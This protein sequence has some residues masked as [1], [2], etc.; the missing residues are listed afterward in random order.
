MDLGLAKEF[1]LSVK[2][3]A[4]KFRVYVVLVFSFVL[5]TI[6]ALAVFWP[7]YYVSS[8]TIVR[9]VTDVIGPLL[10]GAAPVAD[11]NKSEKVRD[12]IYSRKVMSRVVEKIDGDRTSMPPEVFEAKIEEI[13]SQLT[14]SVYAGNRDFTRIS[15]K[16]TS[17]DSA[18]DTLKA[19]VD[20]F[21]VDRIQNKK[22]KSYEAFE[23]ISKQAENY[24]RRLEV[25]EAN[26]KEFKAKSV[27]AT[28]GAVRSKISSL[29]SQLEDLKIEMDESRQIVESTRGQ[30]RVEGQ[31]VTLRK[32]LDVLESRRSGL[33]EQ[34][35]QLL[36]IYQDSYPD[37]ISIKEQIASVDSEINELVGELK[38]ESMQTELPLIEE[39]RKQNSTARVT[40]K[41]QKRR[42]EALQGLLEKELELADEVA[43]N[44]TALIELTRDYD[45]TKDLYEEMLA[46]K[47]SASLTLALN[48]EGQGESY[49]LTD[50]PSYPLKPS[51]LSALHVYLSA[52][53]IAAAIP[54]G[55][56]L[57]FVVLDPRIRMRSKVVS[58]LPE[59]VAFL[60]EV[61]HKTS[62]LSSKL[63]RKDI[64]IL[65]VF[66]VFVMSAYVYLL[67]FSDWIL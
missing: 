3:E 43:S 57:V 61:P 6:V 41:V 46:R 28:E 32:R 64:Y 21:L 25:A 9:D 60:G 56:I 48:D 39:L 13:K 20:E 38:G 58:N 40:L 19:V 59:G 2:S 36:L 8:A 7:K 16:D 53:F 50:P 11:I 65:I 63:L 27:D 42:F 23:F 17:S 30:M 31:N 12:I 26:L 66:V 10:R 33:Q 35:D 29:T 67:F 34:L 5:F 52:P 51:G 15:Y 1:L 22:N 18:Y 49:K 14:V 37:V 47:E 55:L 24:R 54:L 62:S 45:V 44:Q 4:L